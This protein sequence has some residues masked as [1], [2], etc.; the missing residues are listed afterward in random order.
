M[1]LPAFGW[2]LLVVAGA[3]LS[4]AAAVA[5]GGAEA[6]AGGPEADAAPAPVLVGDAHFGADRDAGKSADLRKLD[7]VRDPRAGESWYRGFTPGPCTIH[8]SLQGD[9][10]NPGTLE[11][12]Y[13]TILRGT[14][15]AKA[16]DV[17]CIHA[18]TY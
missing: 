7:G 14:S 2:I 16:G 5:P 12:P 17:I 15:R 10:K 18:G 11:Q 4:C 1:S 6:D 13:A 9:N 8:V 3:S